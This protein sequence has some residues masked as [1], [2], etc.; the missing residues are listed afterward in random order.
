[1]EARE[2]PVLTVDVVIRKDEGFVFVKRGKG[3]FKGYWALPGGVVEYGETVEAAALREAREET[4]LEIKLKRLVGVYSEP[5]RDPR[6]H[7]VSVAFLADAVGGELRAG[8][9]AAAVKV[10]RT[11][12]STLA[13]DHDKIFDAAVSGV[14]NE[15]GE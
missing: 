4:G 15:R 6:G 9:D 5:D 13:F 7:F 1:M 14:K 10:F 11:K 12:P 3:P 8:S 2:L